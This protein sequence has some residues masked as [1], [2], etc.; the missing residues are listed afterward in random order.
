MPCGGKNDFVKSSMS[1]L[2]GTSVGVVV[3]DKLSTSLLMPF[4]DC[5]CSEYFDCD[6]SFDVVN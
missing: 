5:H 2:T 4:I 1:F 6:S 3:F